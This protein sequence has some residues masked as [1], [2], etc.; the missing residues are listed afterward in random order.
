M[1]YLLI[2]L[3]KRKFMFHAY[4]KNYNTVVI[5]SQVL[6]NCPKYYQKVHT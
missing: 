1:I 4:F 3:L 2:N 5:K 6:F